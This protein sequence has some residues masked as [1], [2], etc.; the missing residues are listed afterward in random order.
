MAGLIA[1]PFAHAE[2]PMNTD[3][4]GTL[5]QG[6][7]KLEGVW[8]ADDETRGAEIVFGFSP[9]EKLELEIAASRA[10]DGSAI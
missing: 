1:L 4:A 7:M 6:G 9:F 3:D 2:G 5:A 8:S 10:N